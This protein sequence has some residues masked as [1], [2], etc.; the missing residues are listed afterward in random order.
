MFFCFIKILFCIKIWVMLF[1]RR[2][3]IVFWCF[4]KCCIRGMVIFLDYFLDFGI[5]KVGIL[6]CRYII[7]SRVLDEGFLG[8]YR[9]RCCGLD[10]V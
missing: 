10:V 4:K 6:V 5:E 9:G 7:E 2:C 8:E 3:L 1:M